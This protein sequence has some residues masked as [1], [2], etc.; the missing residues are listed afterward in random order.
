MAGGW[1]EAN[2][3]VKQLV[4]HELIHISDW[5]PTI[6]EATGCSLSD[7]APKLDGASKW[8]VLKDGE[9]SD[10]KE[11][12]HNIDAMSRANGKDDRTFAVG[13]LKSSQVENRIR[14]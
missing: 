1:F 3:S 4:N 14:Y 13:T 6:L 5:F 7:K 9:K 8:K 10:R 11:I 12:L 2:R